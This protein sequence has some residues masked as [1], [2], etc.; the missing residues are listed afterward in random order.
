VR[1]HRCHQLD[2]DGSGDVGHDVERENGHPAKRAAGKAID[3]TQNARGVLLHQLRQGSRI[4]AR[5][6]Y[7]G[8]E[9]IDDER[10]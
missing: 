2:D 3:P 1:G 9:P 10:S 7:I 8:A 4:D 5:H 6:R